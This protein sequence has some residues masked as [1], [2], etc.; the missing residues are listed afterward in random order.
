MSRSTAY[1]L[2]IAVL[3]LYTFYN[4]FAPSFRP[5]VRCACELAGRQQLQ[6]SNASVPTASTTASAPV[7]LNVP[8]ATHIKCT[9]SSLP[10]FVKGPQCRPPSD[11]PV[12]CER[13]P[14]S[15]EKL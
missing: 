6:C 5:T 15:C 7:A 11:L 3:V 2:W 12:F 13:H 4:I 10:S 9:P 1:H 14:L 8:A